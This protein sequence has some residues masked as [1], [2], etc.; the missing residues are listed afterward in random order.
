MNLK[1]FFPGIFNCP[2]QNLSV[3]LRLV[4]FTL[5]G[6]IILIANP[7]FYSHDELSKLDY[8]Q[9]N[10]F[11]QYM[12]TVLNL[13]PD[14]GFAFAD[15][16]VSYS[17]E[18]LITLF[19]P[20]YPFMV[21]LAD[22]LMHAIVACLLFFVLVRLQFSRKAAWISALLFMLNPLV[23]F[24]VGWSGAL[25][26][27]LFILLGLASFLSAE[28]YVRGNGGVNT[29]MSVFLFALL[30]ILSKETALILP[31][32]LLVFPFFFSVAW[33]DRRFW[34]AFAVQSAASVLMV[35]YRLP[36]LMGS[37]GGGSTPDAYT[38]SF[39][40]VVEN[41][42][43]YLLYPFLS[44]L[45][46]IHNW[47]L[48]SPIMIGL[49]AIMH[50]A[51]LA[52]LWKNFSH[53]AV[54]AYLAGYFLFLL[55]V[56]VL[57]HPAS[58]YLYGS[59]IAFGIAFGSLVDKHDGRVQQVVL[60]FAFALAI[61]HTLVN[62]LYFYKT[63]TCMSR[64]AS[65]M[66]SAYYAEGKPDTMRFA[67]DPASP[68]YILLRFTT[69]RNMIGKNHPVTFE[70]VDWAKRREVSKAD[71][72]VFDCD[73]LIHRPEPL[74][75]KMGNWGP[76]SLALN[77]VPNQQPDGRGA[78]W[79]EVGNTH[80]LG[81][82]QVVIGGVVDSTTSIQEKVITASFPPSLFAQPGE[83]E[84]IMRQVASGQE[85][86]VGKLIIK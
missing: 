80:E 27:R 5:V 6:S 55:P 61:W 63:G 13:T 84:V 32:S 33:R 83:K 52:L 45:T 28:K 59:G 46:E 57:S 85:F 43:V 22:V 39:G 1:F 12:M 49:A 30:S 72:Y 15:R 24:S 21:H 41:L 11:G 77:E 58:H 26:D 47:S 9:Q 78:L 60:T 2:E 18:G 25:M 82:M 8:I 51:L 53:K 36:E 64:I 56:S 74:K 65:S 23:S 66:E 69:D 34:T 79:F 20:E 16:P 31:L 3:F 54:L 86:I 38:A 10:G 35:S 7:S 19:L 37:F 76:Q 71:Y 17:I 62:Q 67:A 14:P 42:L 50:L 48:S 29:L 70:M 44:T 68:G 4:V 81:E 40:N 73:C 75:V